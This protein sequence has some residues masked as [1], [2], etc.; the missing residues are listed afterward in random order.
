[1]GNLNK[2]VEGLMQQEVDESLIAQT[3][4]DATTQTGGQQVPAGYEIVA[5]PEDEVVGKELV[6]EEDA[7]AGLEE[8]G[9]ASKDGSLGL[10]KTDENLPESVQNLITSIDKS[11]VDMKTLLEQQEEEKKVKKIKQQQEDKNGFNWEGEFDFEDLSTIVFKDEDLVIDKY[12][13]SDLYPGIGVRTSGS[14]GNEVIFTLP[15]GKPITVNLNPL[16]A[17]GREPFLMLPQKLLRHF[18][19]L[20][21]Y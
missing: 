13:N 9:L 15:N 19:Q 2:T 7:N 14:F 4:I 1:M 6:S 16:T 5:P 10:P 20:S 21:S 8:L 18:F 11:G 12:T 17:A 3:I